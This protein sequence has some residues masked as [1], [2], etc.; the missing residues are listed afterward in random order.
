LV[1]HWLDGRLAFIDHGYTG[2]NAAEAIQ[3]TVFGETSSCIPMVKRFVLLP[4]GW[5]RQTNLRRGG[6][7]L[8]E[9]ADALTPRSPVLAFAILIRKI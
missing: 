9:T 4:R 6:T 2:L 1:L 7:L 8:P 3:Q 5:A